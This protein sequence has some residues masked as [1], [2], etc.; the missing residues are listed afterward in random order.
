MGLTKRTMEDVA[1][2]V[3]LLHWGPRRGPCWQREALLSGY[4]VRRDR[5]EGPPAVLERLPQRPARLWL[6]SESETPMFPLD[7]R[8]GLKHRA[9]LRMVLGLVRLFS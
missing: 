8:S 3:F 2:F 7:S 6:V 9:V 4:T 1:S 5:K